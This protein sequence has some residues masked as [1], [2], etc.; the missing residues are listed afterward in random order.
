M[1]KQNQNFVRA[2]NLVMRDKFE[3]NQ[4][5]FAKDLNNFLSDYFLYDS[6]TVEVVEGASNDMVICVN[7]RNVKNSRVV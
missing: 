4:D 3:M 1:K 2:Q 5:Q 6:L 7:V